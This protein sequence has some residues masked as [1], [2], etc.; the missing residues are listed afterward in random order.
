MKIKDVIQKTP[1]MTEEKLLKIINATFPIV[2][3]EIKNRVQE[4]HKGVDLA[5]AFLD[6]YDLV[7]DKKSYL[8][9][10]QRKIVSEIHDYFINHIAE[11]ITVEQI[12]EKYSISHVS[13]NK[14]FKIMY[15]ETIPKYMHNYRMEYAAKELIR[16]SKSI[17]EIAALVGYDNQ[18]KFSGAFKKK[19]GMTPLEYRRSVS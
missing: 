16:S 8:T 13:L 6:E 12:T 7:Q 4:L 9:K 1:E 11:D 10:G 15:G 14:Y 2:K 5:Q 17:A 3:P 18:S 19:Y